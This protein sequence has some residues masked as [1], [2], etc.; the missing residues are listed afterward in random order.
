MVKLQGTPEEIRIDMERDLLGRLTLKRTRE[1]VTRYRYEAGNLVEI[2]R[3]RHRQVTETEDAPLDRIV[4]AWD[5]M[6]NLVAETCTW[7]PALLEQVGMETKKPLT[8][9]LKHEYDV[10]GNRISTTLPDDERLNMLYYGSGH[11][12]QI[13][14]ESSSG[15]QIISDFERDGL[16]RETKRSQGVVSTRTGYTNGGQVESMRA[17]YE[18]RG[19]PEVLARSWE[20]NLNGE[21]IAARS[22]NA[23]VLRY[24]YDVLGRVTSRRQSPL[25]DHNGQPQALQVTLPEE[26]FA[27]DRAGN[28]WD[29]DEPVWTNRLSA[30]GNLRQSYNVLGQLRRKAHV[31]FEGDLHP[32]RE[33]R[34][35]WNGEEQLVRV[36]TKEGDS[37]TE[38]RFAYDA[39][40]RRIASAGNDGSSVTLAVW[41]GMQLV[42]QRR[43]RSAQL[44]ESSAQHIAT[45]VYQPDSYTP[46]ARVETFGGLLRKLTG[47]QYLKLAG[48]P[49]RPVVYHFHVSPNGTPEAMSNE[50]GRI[51]WRGYAG[52]WGGLVSEETDETELRDRALAGLPAPF[53]QDLRMPGQ[54]HDRA[55]GLHYNTFR[56]YDPETGRFVSEDPIGL[57]GGINLY[58]YAPNPPALSTCLFR[59]HFNLPGRAE[60]RTPFSPAQ[61]FL[62]RLPYFRSALSRA[63]MPDID[64]Q[65]KL[66]QTLHRLLRPGIGPR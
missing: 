4:L 6:G 58:R 13:S 18:V 12:H 9:V 14:L 21:C 49:F 5:V 38:C 42:Q 46:V 34:L 20:Y 30:C 59:M 28:L 35:E 44:H 31:K 2:T 11:L 62:L 64:I 56:Y 33:Q 61:A 65:R 48:E 25:R 19:G 53:P 1:A 8:H 51:V 47:E 43:F 26:Q 41:Q 39:L 36:R 66:E 10:L 7:Y 45:F 3:H 54:W 16:H 55:T 52:T 24:T 27:W 50:R 23:G 32:E 63:H 60:M 17:Q 40:G 37:S 15:V 22:R 57:T 29:P